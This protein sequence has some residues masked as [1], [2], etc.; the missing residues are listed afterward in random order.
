PDRPGRV[1]GQLRGEVL[2]DAK[3]QR[4]ELALVVREGPR[5]ALAQNC[6]ELPPGVAL[7]LFLI[8]A[9]RWARRSS[10]RGPRR[11]GRLCPRGGRSSA[12][13]GSDRRHWRTMEICSG[14]DW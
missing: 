3:R 2:P 6:E 13:G 4:L 10:R 14:A 5:P 1:L 11:R 8:R 12:H 7:A 9:Y